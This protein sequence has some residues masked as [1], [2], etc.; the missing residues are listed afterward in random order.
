MNLFP[1]AWLTRYQDDLFPPSRDPRPHHRPPTRRTERTQIMFHRHQSLALPH[2][3]APFQPRQILPR[4]PPRQPME[5]NLPGP[6]KLSS[7]LYTNSIHQL[8][9]AHHSCGRGHAARILRRF[10]PACGY[11][12]LV[13]SEVFGRPVAWVFPH[14]QIPPPLIHPSPK[15]R[16]IRSRLFFPPP[17]GPI[18]DL[19]LSPET[20]WSLDIS[21]DITQ[22]YRIS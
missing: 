17:Q 13:R 5:G 7:S 4:K 9:K 6:H 21:L 20:G 16:N 19:H 14:R 12:R 2:A 15:L 10:T 8:P 3:N 18:V 11:R 1:L 22:A